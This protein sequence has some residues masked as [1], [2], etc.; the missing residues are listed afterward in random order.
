MGPGQG[1]VNRRNLRR[2]TERSIMA[3][4]LDNMYSSSAG[5]T[6]WGEETRRVQRPASSLALTWSCPSWLR[7]I[8]QPQKPGKMPPLHRGVRGHE[9]DSVP[10]LLNWLRVLDTAELG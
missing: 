1:A 5:R 8:A 7:V 3:A 6:K 10:I 4:R 9:R 2:G